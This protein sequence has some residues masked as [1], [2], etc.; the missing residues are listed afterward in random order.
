MVGLLNDKMLMWLKMWYRL[1]KWG[2]GVCVFI[3][4]VLMVN[5]DSFV[6]NGVG[7][8]EDKGDFV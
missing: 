6:V 5:C 2:E 8:F 7:L 3:C 1:D 4:V